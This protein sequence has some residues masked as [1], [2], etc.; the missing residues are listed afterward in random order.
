MAED[1]TQTTPQEESFTQLNPETLPEDLKK[2]YKSMQADYTR[3]TQDLS[4]RRKEY[5]EREQQWKEQLKTYGAAEQELQQ[6]R[7][8]YKS[9]SEQTEDQ[10]A[11]QQPQQTQQRADQTLSYLDEPGAENI[12]RFV[13]ELQSTY[14][15]NLS[16]LKEEITGLRA[17]LHDTTDRTSRMF[18]YQA[19]LSELGAKYKDLNKKELLEYALK[20]GQPDLEKAYKDLHQDEFIESEVTKRLAEKEKEWRTRGIQGPGKQIILKP[21]QAS[22]K[23]F[24]EA[25]E[26]ILKE[27]AAQGL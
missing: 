18:N 15:K 3:K 11:Q 20:T 6:W 27:R 16:A 9:L 17:A 5:D 23:S 12:K 2:I 10:T 8:W 1:T 4:S 14:D 22:P 26:Q 13:T 25:S 21:N 24:A 7:D 19:Q